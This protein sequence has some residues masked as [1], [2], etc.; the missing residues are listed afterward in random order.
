[1]R[2]RF[3][4]GTR[5]VPKT[6]SETRRWVLVLVVSVALGVVQAA[7]LAHHALYEFAS[8]PLPYAIVLTFLV[9]ALWYRWT[10]SFRE[11]AAAFGVLIGVCATILMAVFTA[12]SRALDRPAVDAFPIVVR[13]PLGD[14][15]DVILQVAGF[16]TLLLLFLAVPLLVMT[17]AVLCAVHGEFAV[18]EWF[19]Q[20]GTL[21]PILIVVTV[22][23][24]LLTGGMLTTVTSNY[25]SV[26]DQNGTPMTVDGVAVESSQVAVTISVHNRLASPMVVRKVELYLYVDGHGWEGTTTEID[27]TVPTANTEQVTVQFPVSD[28]DPETV[29]RAERVRVDGLVS[30][31][32]FDH[33]RETFPV[34]ETAVN[35]EAIACA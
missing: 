17:A 15:A 4:E 20:R 1:M 27:V 12:P 14:P 18:G 7:A 6:G 22:A 13:A 3:T 30:V 32:A 21:S 28:F 29:C 16:R 8:Y 5:L 11:T 33:Y 9:G 10:A 2:S 31:S 23:S 24:L 26:V 34:V 19:G 35:N 25:V